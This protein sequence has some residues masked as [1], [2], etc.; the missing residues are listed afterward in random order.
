MA[1]LPGRSYFHDAVNCASMRKDAESIANFST[2]AAKNIV[3]STDEDL[4]CLVGWVLDNTKAIWQAM[5]EK[6]HSKWIMRGCLAHSV[7]L[8][9]KDFCKFK[10][11]TGRGA[12][13]R[14]FGMKW[15]ESCVEDGNKIAYFLQDSGTARQVVAEKQKE[16]K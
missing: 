13:T 7:A 10:P 3:G 16:V 5:L 8:L 14:S 15:A 12:A 2:T 1:L 6:M 9:M 11:A 4:E